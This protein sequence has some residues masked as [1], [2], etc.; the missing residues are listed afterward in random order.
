VKIILAT[1]IMIVVHVIIFTPTDFA[2][3]T[4]N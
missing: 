1:I 4:E 2:N 3:I